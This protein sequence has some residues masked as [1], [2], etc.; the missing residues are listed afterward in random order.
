[1]EARKRPPRKLFFSVKGRMAAQV[2]FLTEPT[3]TNDVEDKER[4]VLRADVVDLERRENVVLEQFCPDA[5]DL[6]EALVQALGT[7]V[8]GKSA[9]IVARGAARQT[10]DGRTVQYVDGFTVTPL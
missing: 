3:W 4:E 5:Y 6:S 7:N 2:K 10:N 1:M 8:A 9:A